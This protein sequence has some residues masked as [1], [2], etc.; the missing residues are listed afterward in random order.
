[1]IL[2]TEDSLCDKNAPKISCKENG[3]EYIANNPDRRFD[4]R[5]YR[6][7]GELVRMET[8]CDYLVINDT[9]HKAYYIELKGKDIKHAVEQVLAGEKICRDSLERYISYYRIV[10]HKSPAINLFPTN[11]KHLLAKVGP[12]RLKCKNKRLEETLS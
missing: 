5:K 10:P 9:G 1:M 12:E 11:Y 3:M 2:R 7:D 6:L 8:C 4:V